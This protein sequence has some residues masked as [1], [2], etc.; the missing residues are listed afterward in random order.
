MALENDPS[1]K[2]QIK[3]LGELQL[4]GTCMECGN[5]NFDGDY[6]DLGVFFDYEGH[7]AM[8]KTCVVQAGE[9]VGMFT[10]EEHLKLLKDFNDL[11]VA[12]N[13]KEQ[14][15]DNVRNEL[16]AAL[17][18]LG[19]SSDGY[20]LNRPDSVEPLAKSATSDAIAEGADSGE[21]EV[22]ESTVSAGR[23]DTSGPEQS[24]APA[25]RVTKR[26]FQ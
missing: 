2:M 20:G 24:D 25:K 17:T 10:A 8:C 19:A 7:M 1:A 3:S 18:L 16:N 22:T 15:L 5:G 4:P 26:K 13:D 12:H 9:T 23:S 14:E 11:L 21:P 6:L